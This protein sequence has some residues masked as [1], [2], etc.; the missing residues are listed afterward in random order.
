MVGV[1]GRSEWGALELKTLYFPDFV[2]IVL[3]FTTGPN[4]KNSLRRP[5]FPRSCNALRR[6]RSVGIHCSSSFTLRSQK[7]HSLASVCV[8]YTYNKL[9][10]ERI[11]SPPPFTFESFRV[12]TPPWILD[13]LDFL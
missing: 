10:D 13:F 3:V 1:Q 4:G 9:P 5:K 12:P 6:R 8:N 11:K 7:R 2:T